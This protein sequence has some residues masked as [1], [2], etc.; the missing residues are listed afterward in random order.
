MNEYSVFTLVAEFNAYRLS[1]GVIGYLF[2]LLL[3]L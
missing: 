3:F 1:V 2:S